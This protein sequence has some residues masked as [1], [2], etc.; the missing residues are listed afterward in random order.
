VSVQHYGFAEAASFL[1]PRVGKATVQRCH[2]RCPVAD[3]T[4]GR[5]RLLR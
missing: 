4:R 3:R 2:R 1:A 5:G